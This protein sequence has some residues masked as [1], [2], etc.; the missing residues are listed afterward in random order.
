M[1]GSRQGCESTQKG[2]GEGVGGGGGG[3]NEHADAVLQVTVHIDS[4]ASVT[5]SWHTGNRYNA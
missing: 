1:S 4:K 5:H 3:A 2:L